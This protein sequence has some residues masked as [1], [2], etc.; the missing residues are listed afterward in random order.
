MMRFVPLLAL[1]FLA[2]CGAGDADKAPGNVTP[3]EAKALDEAAEMIDGQRPP[4]EPVAPSPA[5]AP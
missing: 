3:D 2:A 1:C 4:G 5:A